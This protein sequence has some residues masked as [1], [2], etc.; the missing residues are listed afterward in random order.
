VNLL[1]SVK[2]EVGSGLSGRVELDPHGYRE[3]GVAFQGEGNNEAGGARLGLVGEVKVV[4]HLDGLTAV[5]A[6]QVEGASAVVVV[7]EVDAG[8]SGGADAG[9][10]VVDVLFAVLAGVACQTK[11]KFVDSSLDQ[12]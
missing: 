11:T 7:D 2:S 1:N 9:G 8:G 3:L 4:V 10:A 12:L 5:L 6:G